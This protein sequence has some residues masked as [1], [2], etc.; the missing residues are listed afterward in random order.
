M[1]MGILPPELKSI[2][3]LFTSDA[4]YAVPK[5]QRSF[6]WGSDEIEE[7]WED[8]IAA[9]TRQGEYFLGT[10]VL[11]RKQSGPQEI[12]DGQQRLA[13]IS[14]VFSAIR[15]VF[16][17]NHDPRA[18]Q[19]LFS[20][21]G[22]KDF[23]RNSSPTPK[24]VLNQINNETFVQHI[25]ESHDLTIINTALRDKNLHPSN[26]L[27]LGAY[28]YFLEQV[29]KEVGVKGTQS[30]D[31][32][33]PLIDTLRSKVM[34][35]TIPVT[36]E[37]DANLFFESLNARGK[38]LAISDLVKN[39]LYLEVGD[40]V[41]RAQQLW[42][43]M[44]N[45]LVHLPIPEYLRH[46]WIA[47]KAEARS[48]NVREKQLYRMI[49]N[50]IG[51]KR[52]SAIHLLEDLR[53]TS[54]D[55]ARISD[56]RLWPDEPAYDDFFIESLNDL[57]LF[58]VTQC[59]PLLINAIQTFSDPKDIAKTF[60]IVANFSF[61]YFIVG[62]QSPGNL[63]RVS[64]NIAYEIRAGTYTSPSHV[65]DALRAVSSDPSFRSDFTLATMPK[66]KTR[67]ARYILAK[68]SNFMTQQST[69]GGAEQVVNPDS[70]QVNLEHILPL[71]L[72]DPWPSYFTR[73]TDPANYITRLGNLTLL[74]AK[75]NRDAADVS[76]P[77][78]KRLALDN[79]NLP[80]NNYFKSLVTWGSVEIEQR[81]DHLGKVAIE[82]WK[83]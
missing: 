62:N 13:S 49:S 55:Y 26:R 69:K 71:D 34:L 58:R 46:Y 1:Q 76:F 79:S 8:L 9:I 38:E 41:H 37:E 16:L 14:M 42:E 60:R 30:D 47:K 7:L 23:S 39:R 27:L 28:K 31:F 63:E 74:T 10:V 51:T 20:F 75:I 81:Q 22:A 68:L 77:E 43:Q 72:H 18:E 3:Q 61:R 17:A 35:I 57:R 15:N 44:E 36:T 80:I 83:L 67:I 29:L 73:D 5:Y 6:A 78:K 48:S 54:T 25:I 45:E 53:K 50:D 64:A 11:Q 65:A 32:L 56:Y 12:I 2:E 33:V 82:V 4:R 40:Q 19:I 52:Q 66:T 21:I 24:L 59:N 70:R